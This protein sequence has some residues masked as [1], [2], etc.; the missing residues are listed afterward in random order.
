MDKKT[1]VQK[2]V[3]TGRTVNGWARFRGHNRATVHSVINGRTRP[4]TY[5]YKAIVADLI[6][7]GYM[8][9]PDE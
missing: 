7:D 9:A 5:A 2:I 4:N 8:D 6:A 3:A 1:V